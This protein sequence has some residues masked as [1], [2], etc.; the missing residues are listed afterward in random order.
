MERVGLLIAVLGNITA[1]L[2]NII[3]QMC[4]PYRTCHAR[5]RPHAG[6]LI[7][8][9]NQGKK[10]CTSIC[11]SK[12]SKQQKHWTPFCSGLEAFCTW[13]DGKTLK[14][15]A[16]F[17]LSVVPSEQN[18]T[19][20]RFCVYR[21]SGRPKFV[22]YRVNVAWVSFEFDIVLEFQF[23]PTDLISSLHLWGILES[24]TKAKAK[25]FR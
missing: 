15:V 12:T 18:E 4:R 13:G 24:K 20:A 14:N 23:L 22:R 6:V 11:K 9:V 21:M 8:S 2:H 5:G 10:C 3:S 19:F 1:L 7:M 25:K 17:I 16:K